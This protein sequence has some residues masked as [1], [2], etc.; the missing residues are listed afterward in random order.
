MALQGIKSVNKAK[1]LSSDV[2]EYLIDEGFKK[3]SAKFS[4]PSYTPKF[5]VEVVR[6]WSEERTNEKYMCC[7]TANEM[8]VLVEDSQ[9]DAPHI[10]FHEEFMTDPEFVEVYNSLIEKYFE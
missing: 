5:P 7:V 9:N 10:T 6:M 1:E 3:T 8:F 4:T 2:R